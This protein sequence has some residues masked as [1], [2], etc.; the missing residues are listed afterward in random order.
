MVDVLFARN[1]FGGYDTA[2]LKIK[3]FVIYRPPRTPVDPD[4]VLGLSTTT[5]AM[6]PNLNYLFADS[7]SKE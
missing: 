4:S 3:N 5:P 2:V 7:I 1:H 6:Q